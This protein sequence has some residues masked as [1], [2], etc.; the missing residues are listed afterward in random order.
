ME[1]EKNYQKAAAFIKDAAAEGAELALLPECNTSWSFIS[2][3]SLLIL[4]LRLLNI[5]G[6]SN[7]RLRRTMQSLGNL[8]QEISGPGEGTQDLYSSRD[9]RWE[10]WWGK[11]PGIWFTECGL[12]HRWQGRDSGEICQEEFMVS[13][14]IIPSITRFTTPDFLPFHS[15]VDNIS[16]CH[17]LSWHLSI[18]LLL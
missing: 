14:E 16:A 8:P 15:F 3:S 4:Q 7:S 12:F 6:S 18:L 5:M 1:I 17:D 13:F 11:E 10:T 2:L 9:N